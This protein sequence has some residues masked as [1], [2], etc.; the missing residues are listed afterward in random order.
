MDKMHIKEDLVYNKHT[1][2]LVG[3]VN[4]GR[5][6]F[7][8]FIMYCMYGWWLLSRGAAS[9]Q[10]G[11]GGGGGGGRPPPPPPLNE[12]LLGDKYSSLKV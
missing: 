8:I 12:T 5:V 9:F 3:F 11:G 4:L 1:G 6:S 2:K 10:G 7:R